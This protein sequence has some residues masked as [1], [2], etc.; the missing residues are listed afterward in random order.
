MFAATFDMFGLLT[1]HV[2][3]DF[4]RFR[5]FGADWQRRWTCAHR[6][7]RKFILTCAPP[8]PSRLHRFPPSGFNRVAE[9]AMPPHTANVYI[10]LWIAADPTSPMNPEEFVFYH[11]YCRRLHVLHSRFFSTLSGLQRD[12]F[13]LAL[14]FTNKKKINRLKRITE[15]EE[16]YEIL[17]G[18]FCSAPRNRVPA[19]YTPKS[20]KMARTNRDWS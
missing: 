8:N 1:Y 17:F 11:R 4:L 20:V 18:F 9:T 19:A 6:D 14:R 16:I 5:C 3:V 2:S 7:R 15:N 12:S 13:A 10:S